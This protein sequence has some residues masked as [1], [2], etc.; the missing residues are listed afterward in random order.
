MLAALLNASSI[1]QCAAG[2]TQRLH[3]HNATGMS[4]RG[5][6]RPDPELECAH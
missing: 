4:R 1:I 2:L 6:P 5:R 3:A